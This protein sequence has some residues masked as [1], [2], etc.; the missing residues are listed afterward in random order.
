M[1]SRVGFTVF[2]ARDEMHLAR[3]THSRIFLITEVRLADNARRQQTHSRIN[4]RLA[5]AWLAEREFAT[6]RTQLMTNCLDQMQ[7]RGPD[8]R[9]E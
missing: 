7:R 1:K 9:I 2:T 5:G 6:K 4:R 8:L 3:E